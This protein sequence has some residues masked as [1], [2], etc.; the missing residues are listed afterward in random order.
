MIGIFAWWQSSLNQLVTLESG[1]SFFV[2]D[3]DEI[4]MKFLLMLVPKIRFARNPI[5]KKF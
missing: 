4:D 5:G 1:F 3:L 2:P